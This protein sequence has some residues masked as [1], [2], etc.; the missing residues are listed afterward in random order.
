MTI[1]EWREVQETTPATP[2][3][4]GAVM[5]EAGRLGLT[6]RTE[7]LKIFAALLDLDELGSVHD[8]VMGQ[9]GQLLHALQD[10]GSRAELDAATAAPARSRAASQP[11]VRPDSVPLAVRSLLA[12]ALTTQWAPL[13][14]DQARDHAH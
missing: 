7:R 11:A 2:N 8:L 3:Q 5:H 9:A 13:T 14:P 6:D 4:R 1:E 10:F 12:I